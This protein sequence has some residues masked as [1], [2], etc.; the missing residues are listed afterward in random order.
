MA[1]YSTTPFLFAIIPD[2]PEEWRII[3]ATASRT[4]D[5]PMIFENVSFTKIGL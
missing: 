3:C 2:I 4:A 1:F 5:M